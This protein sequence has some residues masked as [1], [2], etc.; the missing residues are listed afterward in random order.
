MSDNG[1]TPA[2]DG[3]IYVCCACGKT[4]PTRYG[5]DARN[6][7]VAMPGWD[8]SCMCNAAL[9]RKDDLI[10]KPNGRVASIREGAKPVQ[11]ALPSSAEGGRR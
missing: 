11:A 8:E 6:R 5:F 4:S 1:T 7:N 3:C 2:P 9:F 10:T